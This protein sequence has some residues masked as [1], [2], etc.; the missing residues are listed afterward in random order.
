[1]TIDAQ[2]KKA[3]ETRE[4]FAAFCRQKGW[5]EPSPA[6]PRQEREAA[7]YFLGLAAEAFRVGDLGTAAEHAV[8]AA[9]IV[10]EGEAWDE[11]S[12]AA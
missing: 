12:A 3:A 11:R 10:R 4:A 7:G 9:A 6:C 1:M 2:A 5:K 8:V